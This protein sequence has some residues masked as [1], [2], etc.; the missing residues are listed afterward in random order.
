MLVYIYFLLKFF[1][2]AVVR[3]LAYSNE[4]EIY[5]DEELFLGCFKHITQV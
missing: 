1:R 5:G 3:G 2:L 4:L